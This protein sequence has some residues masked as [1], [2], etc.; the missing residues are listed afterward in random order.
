MHGPGFA[1]PREGPPSSAGVVALRA[2]FLAL[3][4]LSCG[5][6]A[7]VTMFR[8][9]VLRKRAL[10]WLLF[11]VTVVVTA[12]LIFAIAVWGSDA[13]AEEGNNV[14]AFVFLGLFGMAVAVA[15]HFLVADLRRMDQLRLE[16]QRA[17]SFF[18]PSGPSGPPAGSATPPVG[19]FGPPPGAPSGPGPGTGPAGPSGPTVPGYGYPP[20]RT[21]AP[22]YGYPAGNAHRAAPVPPPPP[23][24]T[25]PPAPAPGPGPVHPQHPQPPARPG[26]PAPRIDQVRAELD[27]LSDYLRRDRDDRGDRREPGDRGEQGR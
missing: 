7:W 6:L 9:A 21:A 4:L 5:L 1:P 8:L 15:V 27:E 2:L 19:G 13:D 14:D 10:D 26:T 16:Q 3:A 20:P 24:P 18:V 22:G 12:L 25:P 23:A 11:A 17:G